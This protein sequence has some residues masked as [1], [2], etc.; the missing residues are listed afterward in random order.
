MPKTRPL[1]SETMK[2]AREMDALNCEAYD[3]TIH[4]AL[5]RLHAESGK[6]HE[7]I[8]YI[9]GMNLRTWHKRVAYPSTL[10]LPEI[11]KIA[12]LA[13]RYGFEID[14]NIGGATA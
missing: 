2:M 7:E 5:K 6:N 10:K 4:R 14:F 13:K 12:E 1:G 8:A 3:E 9:L 11:R